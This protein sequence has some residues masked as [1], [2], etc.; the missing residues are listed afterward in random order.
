MV[1]PEAMA[2]RVPIVISALSGIREILEDRK[3]SLVGSCQR[4]RGLLQEIEML[5]GSSEIRALLIRA[6]RARDE[7]QFLIRSSAAKMLKM[8]RSL[9]GAGKC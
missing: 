9:C 8:Y 1:L 4:R 7:A 5:A 6:A 2:L 3:G